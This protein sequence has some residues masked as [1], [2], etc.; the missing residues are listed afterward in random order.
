MKAEE[1][2]ENKEF[3]NKLRNRTGV[4]DKVKELFTLPELEYATT[5]QVA[6]YYEVDRDVIKTFYHRHTEEC[7]KYGVKKEK[8]K[9]IVAEINK[10]LNM[11]GGIDFNEECAKTKCIFPDIKKVDGGFLIDGVRISYASNLLFSRKA[12]LYISMLLRDSEV[13]KKVKKQL[14]Y[15]YVNGDVLLIS[16]RGTTY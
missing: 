10:R 4:F 5:Q 12:T 13:A 1:Y 15:A 3:R 9:D 2:F 6:D 11:D 14:Y 7:N 8:R 16:K